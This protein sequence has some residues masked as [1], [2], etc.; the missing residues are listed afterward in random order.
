V[1]GETL[2]KGKEGE[3]DL[4]AKKGA[5]LHAVE[6]GRH[7][8]EKAPRQPRERKQEGAPFFPERIKLTTEAEAQV[9]A[10]GK[11]GLL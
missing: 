6:R 8:G 10:A 2:V 7:F 9:L 4:L 11:L 1:Q 5:L 3:P